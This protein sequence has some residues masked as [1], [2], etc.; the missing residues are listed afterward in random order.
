MLLP[1]TIW[2]GPRVDGMHTA[3]VLDHM[4]KAVPDPYYRGKGTS[5]E[6]ANAAA[7]KA[8]RKWASR[9]RGGIK[10]TTRIP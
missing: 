5:Q 4:G 3:Y 7:E 2:H 10:H 6:K 9:V 8:A 1:F